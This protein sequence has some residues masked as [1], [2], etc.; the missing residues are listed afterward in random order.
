M[1]PSILNADRANVQS[2]IARVSGSSDLLHL[3][4]MDNIFVSN[5]TFSFAQSAEIIAH[6]PLPVD[7]HLMI[8]N[9]D[10]MAPL[11]AEAGAAS[12]TF[13]F[14]ASIN[15]IHTLQAIRASGARAALAVKP[16]TS[17]SSIES[18]I[19]EL[20]MLLV[21]T[22]EPGFGGQSFMNEMMPKISQARE[23][24]EKIDREIW[25]QVDGGISV[26]TIAIAAQAGADAFVAGSAV[27]R[28][29]S[30]SEMLDTLRKLA[31]GAASL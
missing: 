19:P 5:L 3:D 25:L 20:D 26:E 8:I 15:P 22:V 24:I 4:V 31:V 21:M 16:A 12:V 30:P 13:H 6:S 11:Y 14:E 29:Q 17:F 7:A 28:A 23:A 1:C 27:Y 18:L 10:E 2:E 9:P